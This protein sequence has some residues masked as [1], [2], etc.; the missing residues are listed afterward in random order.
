M[1]S[2]AASLVQEELRAADHQ[3]T[4]MTIL[5]NP[6][7]K[8]HVNKSLGMGQKKCDDTGKGSGLDND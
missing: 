3:S 2:G 1:T 8:R 4:L 7:V 6:I 5:K